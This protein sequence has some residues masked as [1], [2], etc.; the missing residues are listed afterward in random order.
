MG[1]PVRFRCYHHINP[2]TGND[3]TET[4]FMEHSELYVKRIR[5]L[6]KERGIAA[7]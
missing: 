2:Q 6:C 3:N 1:K 7:F 5:K 4:V